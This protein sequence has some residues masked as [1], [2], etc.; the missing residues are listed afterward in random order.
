MLAKLNN[1]TIYDALKTSEL[2][3]N[4]PEPQP[5]NNFEVSISFCPNCGAKLSGLG[6]FCA[7]CGSEIN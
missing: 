7:L 4:L 1:L 3:M 5:V 2:Q 6:K